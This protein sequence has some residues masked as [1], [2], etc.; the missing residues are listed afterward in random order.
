[1]LGG[2]AIVGRVCRTGATA[3]AIIS[4]AEGAK[5][6]WTA[7]NFQKTL[8]AQELQAIQGPQPGT[9]T[10]VTWTSQHTTAK[11]LGIVGMSGQLGKRQ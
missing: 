4:S 1:M 3:G 10:P 7:Y 2:E 5:V 8:G 9:G 6:S 11:L